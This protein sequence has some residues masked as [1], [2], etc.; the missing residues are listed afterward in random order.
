[1]LKAN[2]LDIY[3]CIK[4]IKTISAANFEKDAKLSALRQNS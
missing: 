1:M 3:K 2:M 4:F